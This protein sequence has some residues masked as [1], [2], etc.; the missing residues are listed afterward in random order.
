MGA[1]GTVSEDCCD[2]VETVH[3]QVETSTGVFVDEDMKDLLEAVWEFGLR[4]KYSCQ[5]GDKIWQHKQMILVHD[6]YIMFPT[7]QEALKFL[8]TSREIVDWQTI[9]TM[10][11]DLMPKGKGAC[12]RWQENHHL[13]ITTAWSELVYG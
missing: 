10:T 12:V 4:T 7:V 11:M 2:H 9:A 5:G 1:S 13:R 3:P 8:T 6:A